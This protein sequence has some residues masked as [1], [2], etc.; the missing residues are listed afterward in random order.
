LNSTEGAAGDTV[1]LSIQEKARREELE[2]VDRAN[3]DRHRR[4]TAQK[5]LDMGKRVTGGV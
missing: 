3:R 5:K 1:D 2:E 4:E